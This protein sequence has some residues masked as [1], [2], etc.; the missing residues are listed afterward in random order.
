M[1]EKNDGGRIGKVLLGISL[2]ILIIGFIGAMA[3]PEG[4]EATTTAETSKQSTAKTEEPT[5]TAKPKSWQVVTTLSGTTSKRGDVFEL[6]GEKARM[7]YTIEGQYGYISPYI[8][9]EG[10]SIQ[11]SGGFAE[12]SMADQPGETFIVQP[13]GR[14]Y[15]DVSATGNWTVTIEELK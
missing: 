12:V 10:D 7:K 8:V 15:L 14:Y 6:S 13:A 1:T 11:E 5:E 3:A 4:P 9:E 2:A